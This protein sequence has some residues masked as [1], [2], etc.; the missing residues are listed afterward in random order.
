MSP[1]TAHQSKGSLVLEYSLDK[2]G[3]GSKKQRCDSRYLTGELKCVMLMIHFMKV[4]SVQKHDSIFNTGP[5]EHFISTYHISST[6]V[7]TLGTTGP[8]AHCV[9]LTHRAV[10]T[11][12]VLVPVGFYTKGLLPAFF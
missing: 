12:L 5:F 7:N 8:M 1:R 11:A 9:L 6:C 3:A 4:G 2:R 10:F